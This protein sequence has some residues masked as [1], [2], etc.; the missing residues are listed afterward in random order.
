MNDIFLKALRCEPTSRPPIW[1]MR[2]AGRYMPEY[3]KIRQNHSFRDLIRNPKLAAEIT[4]L[5]LSFGVDAAILFSDILILSEL[6]GFTIDYTDGK[7]MKLRE[8]DQEVEFPVDRLACVGETIG[9]LKTRLKVP[10]IGFC[11]GPYTVAKYMNRITPEW[12]SK[13]TDASIEYLKLQINAGVDAIQIFDS[14]AGYLDRQDFQTLSLPYL[15]KIADAIRPFPFIL[16]CRGSARYRKELAELNPSGIGFDWER[17]MAELRKET[18]ATIAVQG[19]LDPDILKGPLPILQETTE[20]L[21]ASMQGSRGYIF[22]L[23]HGVDKETPVENVQ[24]L[25]QRVI[26]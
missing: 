8:P 12:L 19:N 26:R 11:G 4:Q 20:K 16:F 6:F 23:G 5:P 3:Q 13:I 18:P 21:L 15:K 25:V 9:L 22:N 24:W 10:L 2:Q 14:W 17:P 7:G 1:L